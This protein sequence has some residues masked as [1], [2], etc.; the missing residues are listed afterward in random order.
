MTLLHD[1][2]DTPDSAVEA[3]LRT[4][5]RPKLRAHD[6][7]ALHRSLLSLGHEA[8]AQGRHTLAYAFFESAYNA[9]DD[10]G[11]LI[12]AINMRLK[13]GQFALAA[14]L[15]ARLLEEPTW[16]LSPSQRELVERKMDEAEALALRA[17]TSPSMM[18]PLEDEVSQLVGPFEVS[19]GRLAGADTEELVV[20]LRRQGHATNAVDDVD[21]AQLWF[22]CAWALSRAASDL[23]SAANMRLKRDDTCA[24]AE[25]LYGWLLSLGEEALG[26]HEVEVAARKLETLGERRRELAMAE[27]TEDWDVAAWMEGTALALTDSSM[28]MQ[29][30]RLCRRSQSDRRE[31]ASIAA[32]GVGVVPD[33]FE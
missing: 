10:L 24:A 2:A 23:L 7:E 25:A 32:A 3:V 13:L 1:G 15:Y 30:P 6:R 22:D 4:R 21:A 19:S 17:Q 28:V 33:D 5:S 9:K 27:A 11:G 26:E 14:R 31:D 12:S 20:L 8:N 29:P 16:L 18:M